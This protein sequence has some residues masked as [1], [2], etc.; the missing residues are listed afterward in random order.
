MESTFFADRAAEFLR[1][2]PR[3]SPFA[4]VVGFYEPH[5]PVPVPRRVGGPLPPGRVR[6]PRRSPRPTAASSRR[7]SPALT[8]D[9]VQGIQAAYYTSLSF[10]DHQVGR[11][12]DALDASGLADDTIV[13]YLGDNGYMLGQHGRFEK[14]CFYEPA[15]RVPLIVRWPGHLPGRPAGRPSWSSWS[16]SCRPCSTCSACRARP[17][18][19][20]GASMPLLEG[21]PGATGRDVVFSEYLENEEAMARS[22]RYKLIVGTGPPAPAGRLR[23]PAARCPAPTSGSTTSRPTPARRP[24]CAAGPSWPRS[25]R[26]TCAAGS[27]TGS[28]RPARASSRVPPGPLRGR[29]DPLVP[30]PPR[31]SRPPER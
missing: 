20:A 21:E 13:V 31:R 27:T 8:P 3:P 23:R 18:C 30:G 19:T 26:P 16:T 28:S 5:S 7:S 4:L 9:E 14:H 2:P 1:A 10:L 12:L 22:D 29:G 11:V 17:T 6:R 15:V 24:T 25:S